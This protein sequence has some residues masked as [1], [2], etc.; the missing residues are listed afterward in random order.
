MEQICPD[1]LAAALVNLVNDGGTVSSDDLMTATARV[2][3]WN[4]RGT[5]ITTSLS[6]VIDALLENGSITG[7]SS[8]LTI[9]SEE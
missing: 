4:R 1:E 6:Y 3:G 9:P 5:E 7:D 2:Y 8:A